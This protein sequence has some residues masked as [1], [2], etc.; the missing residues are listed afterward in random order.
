MQYIYYR[1]KSEGEFLKEED[2]LLGWGMDSSRYGAI[3]KARERYNEE[4]PD[5][6]LPLRSDYKENYDTREGYAIDGTKLHTRHHP[7]HDKI[8]LEVE[9][10]KRY[11]IDV[12]VIGFYFGKILTLLIREE[13]SKSHGVRD[14]EAI[15]CLD[16]DT[17][18]RIKE[19]R[20]QYKLIDK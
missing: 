16:P 18:E 19:N 3:C 12:V 14:W 11:C 4:N 10:G 9:T 2:Y 5:K 17:I 20:E 15:T 1:F 7:L 8:L 6:P 13:G